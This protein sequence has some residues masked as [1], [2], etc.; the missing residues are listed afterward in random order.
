MANELIIPEVEGREAILKEV[1]EVVQDATDLV[2]RNAEEYEISVA[3]RQ[4][5]KTKL[6]FALDKVN[7]TVNAAYK[8]HQAACDLRDEMTKPYLRADEIVL[9][10][11]SKYIAEQKRID[12]ERK[13]AAQAEA[14]RIEE[15]NRKAE[16]KELENAGEQK[17]AEELKQMP[18]DIPQV[19]IPSSIP[20]VRGATPT[21]RWIVPDANSTDPEFSINIIELA[22]YVIENP[23]F[24][25]FLI[26]NT[27]ALRNY[28]VE[29]KGNVKIPG[30]PARQV[31]GVSIR[32]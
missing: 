24:R 13:A 18:L 22:K 17:A 1:S 5:M 16:L 30:C 21:K 20:R 14:R 26:P 29:R 28:I 10:K 8:A 23:D 11:Q 2:V 25:H 4:Q 27:A 6:A 9:G 7:P 19:Q 15:E 12:Q 3:F 31:E 32:K